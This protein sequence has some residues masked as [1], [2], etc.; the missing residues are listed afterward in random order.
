M[1]VK[2]VYEEKYSHNQT[3]ATEKILIDN[4]TKIKAAFPVY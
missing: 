3:K 1:H 2:E 4:T